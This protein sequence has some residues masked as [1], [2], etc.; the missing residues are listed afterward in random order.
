MERRD[1][2]LSLLRRRGDW[3]VDQLAGD[4]E[5]SRRTILRD[6][7]LLRDRGFDITGMS[8]P[9]GGVRLEATSVAITSHLDAG[10]VVALILAVAVSE[11]TSW[12]PFAVSAQSALAKIEAALPAKRVDELQRLMQ[13]VLID[14][15]MQAEP[16]DGYK[17]DPDLVTVFE[18]AFTANMM[19][20]FAY[21]DRHGSRTRRRVEP[22]GLLIR[23]PLWYVIA[24]DPRRDGPRLFRADRIRRP[25]VTDETFVPRPHDLVTDLCSQARPVVPLRAG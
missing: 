5:V 18:Q 25:A 17:I 22:H 16:D 7:N 12:V 2:L 19:L 6:V 14:E 3:T 24:W 23:A 11:S 15:A 20:A 9:G 10:E 1:Q 8:G 21:T 13:R 4:L